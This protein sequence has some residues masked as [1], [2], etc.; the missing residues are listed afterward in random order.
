MV[1]NAIEDIIDANNLPPGRQALLPTQCLTT[2]VAR[3]KK[4]RNKKG[5]GLAPILEHHDIQ[6][7]PY[8]M[9]PPMPTHI[10]YIANQK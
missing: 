3:P 8:Y 10:K 5:G 7:D 9:K 1:Q 2:A 4:G 6:N